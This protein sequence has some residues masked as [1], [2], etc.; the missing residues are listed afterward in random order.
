LAAFQFV[1]KSWPPG[2]DPSDCVLNQQLVSNLAAPSS[3]FEPFFG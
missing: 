3:R 1:R 2:H